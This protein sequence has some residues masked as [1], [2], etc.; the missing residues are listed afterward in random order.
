MA[1]ERAYTSLLAR[2]SKRAVPALSE[3]LHV[4]RDAA[5]EAFGA[6]AGLVLAGLA[7]HQHRR[8]GDPRAAPSVLEKYG[9]PADVDAPEIAIGAHLARPGLDAR[10]GGLLGDAAGTASRW[11]A[12]RTGETEDAMSRALAASAPLALGALCS[13]TAN[14]ELASWLANVSEASL[15]SPDRLLDA[16]DPSASAFRRVRQA[17]RPWLSRW[18]A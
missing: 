7:R 4:P 1:P 18:R 17:G 6:T 3:H 13:A 15:E 14:G 2:A 8:P 9:R 10:L 5:A 16:K 12:A 11:L